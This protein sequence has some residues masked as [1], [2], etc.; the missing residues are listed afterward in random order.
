MAESK[1]STLEGND[2]ADD[3]VRTHIP[4]GRW[5][6]AWDLVKNNFVRF[7]LI[8][9]VTLLFCVPSIL[10]VYFRSAYISSMGYNYP[11]ASNPLGVYPLTPSMQGVPERITLSA[12]ILYMSLFVA[13]MLIACVGLSGAC[14]SI[15][16][17]LN[18]HGQFSFKSYF[19]GV[20]VCYFSVLFPV[21]CVAVLSFATFMVYDWANITIADGGSKGGPI[22]AEV[23][24]TIFTV[25]VAIIAFWV[26]AVGVS[27]K[28]KFKYLIKNSMVLL[29][30]TI[31]QTLFMLAI[32]LIPVW[33]LLLGELLNW[34]KVLTYVFMIFFGMSYMVLCW[35]AYTQWVF[36]MFITPAVKKEEEARKANLTPKQLAAEK[37]EEELAVARE[38]L[39][40]G[41]SELVG[42]P[43]R[44]IDG[45]TEVKEV[46]VAFSRA[47]I[48]R[49]AGDRDKIKGEID[50]YYEQHRTEEK[51]VEY[52]RM[53]AEREKAVK[54]EGKKGKKK[55]ISS[56]ALLK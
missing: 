17:L 56:N 28:V 13:S 34:V 47:D 11:F 36:D 39:A 16:R 41:K 12:D 40:A 4:Q 25:L 48:A 37:H 46:G 5:A 14:Y 29:I 26:L 9:V 53:F 18:T 45:G 8:N 27:Y 43:I 42:R 10:L 38:I 1:V 49:V 55:K 6:D 35:M 32:T 22:T 54:S 31:V 24:I 15:K 44:P 7:I 3:Y 21:L 2:L 51:Y 30:G 52:E 19:H 20:R 33:L 50:E 23:F